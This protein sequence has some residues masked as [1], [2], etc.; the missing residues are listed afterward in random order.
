MAIQVPA[1]FELDENGEATGTLYVYC[2]EDCADQDQKTPYFDFPKYKHGVGTLPDTQNKCC[3]CGKSFEHLETQGMHNSRE[4]GMRVKLCKPVF[5]E[6]S[7]N[8]V[9]FIPK[10]MT[11]TIIDIEISRKLLVNWDE[12]LAIFPI[13]DDMGEESRTLAETLKGCEH[14]V[15]MGDV[16]WV[17]TR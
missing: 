9:R 4:K 5:I 6:L 17:E 14:E 13:Q 11:G 7:D 10:G 8:D 2:S 1:I 3:Y 15:L 12:A 16:E